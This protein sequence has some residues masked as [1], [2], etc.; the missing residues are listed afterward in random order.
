MP[1]VKAFALY[2]GMALLIDF[3]LQIT[4]FIALLTLDIKRQEDQR[5]DIL[6]CVKANT[7][8]KDTKKHVPVL[9]KIFQHFYGPF[10]LHKYV[11]PAVMIIFL[12]FT[13]LSISVVPKIEIGLDQELSMPDD[14]F[15]LKFFEWMKLYLSVGPPIYLK[16]IP[17]IQSPYRPR[18]HPTNVR[19]QEHDVRF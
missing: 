9:F 18:A 7:K 4:A 3:L 2:A 1:A 15:V 11:R 19:C 8:G 13:C 17:T 14:S 5:L 12:G 6:C 10:L 16:R